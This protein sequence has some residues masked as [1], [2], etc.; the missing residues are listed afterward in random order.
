MTQGPGKPVIGITTGDINGIGIECIIKVFSDQRIL[1]FC[2]PVLFG[3][4]KLVNFYRKALPESNVNYNNVKDLARLNAKQLNILNLWEE[5][6]P[7]NPG[8]LNETGGKYAVASLV[9][10]AQALKEGKIHA[11]VTA[12]LHKKN[13]MTDQFPYTGHTPF[14]KAYFEA[15]DVVMMMVASNMRVA[16]LTEHVPIQEVAKHVTKENI[17]SKL[18]IIKDSMRRDFGIDKPRIAVL[19]LNPHAGDEGLIGKEDDEII[20]PT[21]SEARRGDMLVYGPYSADA[22]FA[23]GSHEKF[24]VVLAMYH[25]QGLIPF[26]SLAKGEGVNYTAGLSCI[27]TSPDHGTA[28]DIAG[29]DKADESSFREA[30]FVALDIYG[31]RTGYAEAHRNPLRKMSG[32]LLRNAVDE[33]IEE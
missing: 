9:A 31:K 25:D 14:L 15:R 33:R 2:T 24:D 19:G 21:V 28:F 26:K 13:V 6:M 10:A 27:R 11:L 3:S 1:E 20:R 7:V 29:K 23:R 5:E 17:I 30:I 16:L 18:R 12:P 4:N 32:G 22:F 8:I